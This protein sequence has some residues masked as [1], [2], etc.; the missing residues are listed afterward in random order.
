MQLANEKQDFSAQCVSELIKKE[1]EA[2]LKVSNCKNQAVSS[3][4]L[5]STAKPLVQYKNSGMPTHGVTG[6][7]QRQLQFLL[8]YCCQAK[9]QSKKKK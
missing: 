9:I 7:C 6:G 4:P 5:T 3:V 1:R 2:Q 8:K